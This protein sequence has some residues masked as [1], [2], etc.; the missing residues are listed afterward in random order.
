VGIFFQGNQALNG[1]QGVL[2]GDGLRCVG[3]GVRRLEV[4]AASSAGQALSSVDVAS[5]GAAA[6]GMTRHYQV[7]YSD[8][9]GSPCGAGFNFTNALSV[10][11]TL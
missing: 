7:W 5:R 1:G 4:F 11:W 2:F 8:A 10:A 3:Q 9:G 6:A